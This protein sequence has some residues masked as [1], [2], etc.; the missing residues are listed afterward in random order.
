MKKNY[1]RVFAII[2][3]S[4]LFLLWVSM[5]LLFRYLNIRDD[6]GESIFYII[7]KSSFFPVFCFV[8]WFY[9]PHKLLNKYGNDPVY[10]MFPKSKEDCMAKLI[11]DDFFPKHIT[12]RIKY[13]IKNRTHNETVDMLVDA[14][15]IDKD[16]YLHKDFFSKEDVEKSHK[17]KPILK[18]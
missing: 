16:G 13:D 18:E 5:F 12:D 7:I 2:N 8:V 4:I 1:D 10:Y 9:M 15:I 6:L 14:K 3:Y 11:C 17:C